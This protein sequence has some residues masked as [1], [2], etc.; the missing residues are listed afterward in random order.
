MLQAAAPGVDTD[1][2]LQADREH[3]I[4]P[5]YHPSDHTRPLLVV[6]GE[7][8]EIVDAHGK[9]YFDALSGLWNVA[10]GHGR[11][12]LADAAAAPMA[13]P[14]FNNNYV[15]LTNQPSIRLAEELSQL[16]Y[17]HLNAV[18]F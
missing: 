3:L 17:P 14:A 4:H 9:R 6:R 11:K 12:E 8:A 5:L 1:Q 16:A 10:V 13:T 15:G 7:G 18:Y 2:L